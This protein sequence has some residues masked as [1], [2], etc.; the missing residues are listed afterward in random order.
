MNL[1]LQKSAPAT[2]S[3]SPEFAD[4][5]P[6][7]RLPFDGALPAGMAGC[8]RQ[9][10]RVTGSRYAVFGIEVHEGV[11]RWYRQRKKPPALA[12]A[13]RLAELSEGSG[14]TTF[15]D[16]VRDAGTLEWHTIACHPGLDHAEHLVLGPD[17]VVLRSLP[18][19]LD[20]APL[21]H[22]VALTAR[23]VVVL[24]LPVVYRQAAA[25]IGARFPYAWQQDRPAR[26]GLLP[27]RPGET[28]EP[29]WF[30][31]DP[32]YIF[33]HVNAFDDGDRVVL[34]AI[35]HSRA[36]DGNQLIAG[37]AELPHVR[38]WTIDP[39]TGAVDARPVTGPADLAVI[40]A[41]RSGRRH[42]YVFSA[43]GKD[44][45]VSTVV[46]HDVPTGT[47][48]KRRFVEGTRI[49][50]P[51]F[52]PRSHGREGDGWL[53]VLTRDFTHQH[54]DMLVLDALDVAGPPLATIHLP[55]GT[56]LAGH[57]TWVPARRPAFRGRG[58]N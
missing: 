34:D 58:D 17:G 2:V 40:D 4:S 27:R 6:G 35:R 15:A 55:I 20:G 42:R 19:T 3:V 13:A 16:P 43:T 46:R 28:G 11:V 37:G 44:A 39:N 50:Q 52:V 8:F 36:Y 23:F 26:I 9:T 41:R 47:E 25:L 45:T 53:L 12:P 21:V 29:R 18:F 51:V 5:V 33:T 30:P 57:T 49:G 38:R 22:T 48:R 54:A 32:C 1:A 10:W 56:P 7:R 31:V 14:R 24:D